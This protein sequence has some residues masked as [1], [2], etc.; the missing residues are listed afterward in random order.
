M[1]VTHMPELEVISWKLAENI[2]RP[3]LSGQKGDSLLATMCAAGTSITTES[4]DALFSTVTEV[5]S[6]VEEEREVDG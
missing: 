3:L 1:A 6:R 4:F 2:V 5:G